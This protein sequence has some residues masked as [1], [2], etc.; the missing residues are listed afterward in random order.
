MCRRWNKSLSNW[1]RTHI[2]THL[3][4]CRVHN[5]LKVWLLKQFALLMNLFY[6][7]TLLKVQIHLPFLLSIQF[8]T[9]W[10][11]GDLITR[12]IKICQ[13]TQTRGRCSSLKAASKLKTFFS[14]SV[15]MAWLGYP[16][17]KLYW[18]LVIAISI[19]QDRFF[20]IRQSINETNDLDVSDK[21]KR[22]KPS[23]R[24][25]ASIC[26][27]HGGPVEMSRWFPSQAGVMFWSLCQI[28]QLSLHNTY[29]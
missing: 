25:S 26:R 7:F 13:K 12:F 3:Y 24:R 15:P 21:G 4:K 28:P 29:P 22:I 16:S 9:D 20:K 27:D 5:Q 1:I 11:Q 18:V 14:I 2:Q 19:N 17:I 8:Q 23:G 10:N 6:L